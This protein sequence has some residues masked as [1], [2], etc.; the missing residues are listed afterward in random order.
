[1]IESA[2]RYHRTPAVVL[3]IVLPLV[4]WM[5]IVVMARDMYGPMT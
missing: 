5:W 2:L 4:S 1:M 3:L